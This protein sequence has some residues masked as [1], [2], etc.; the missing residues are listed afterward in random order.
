MG[1]SSSCALNLRQKSQ[2]A[3][4]C[5]FATVPTPSG[6][7]FF[8]VPFEYRTNTPL[9]HMYYTFAGNAG[10]SGVAEADKAFSPAFDSAYTNHLQRKLGLTG[11][12]LGSGW[13]D[14]LRDG[15]ASPCETKTELSP[16]ARFVS[17]FFR[18]MST[19]ETDFTDTWR[20]LL[21]VPALSTVPKP[22]SAGLEVRVGTEGIAEGPASTSVGLD[23]AG[24]RAPVGSRNRDSTAKGCCTLDGDGPDVTDEDVLRPLVPVLRAAGASSDRMGDW[25]EWTREFMARIDTQASLCQRFYGLSPE[26]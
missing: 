1:L 23:D 13:V 10:V 3:S 26:F 8:N 17:R 11:M 15:G 14:V 2:S 16:D 9:G 4:L 21:D 20:A 6:Q 18:L 19:C 24:K 5:W 7:V 25:A 12:E 22:T